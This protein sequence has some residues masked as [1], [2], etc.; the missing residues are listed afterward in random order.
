MTG[1]WLNGEPRSRRHAKA[2]QFLRGWREVN[3]NT[4]AVA[5]QV[6]MLFFVLSALLAPWL[7]QYDP[8]EIHIYDRLK[9]PSEEHW[10]GTDERGRDILSRIIYGGRITLYIVALS[11]AIITPLGVAVGCIAGYFGGW[12]RAVLM[13]VTDIFLAFPSLILALALTA[14]LGPGLQNTILAIGLSSWPMLARLTYAETLRIS[15]SDYVLAAQLQG[16]SHAHVLLRHVVPMCMPVVLVRTMLSIAGVILTAAS[17]GFLGLG[18]QPPTPEW[19]TML[20]QGRRYIL[21]Y[22]WIATMPG[23]AILLVSLAFNLLGDGLR[24]ALDPRA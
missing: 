2:Q 16:A 4:L 20:A 3:G 15:G 7:S 23:L 17:L 8:T 1:S 22:W 9:P 14:A 13:Q 10:L 24:D 19:G 5:G 6:A 12:T 18:A 11:L 21:D